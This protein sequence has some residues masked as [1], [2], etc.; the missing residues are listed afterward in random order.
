ML[1][2]VYCLTFYIAKIIYSDIR[3]RAFVCGCVCLLLVSAF[4][5]ETY[6]LFGRHAMQETACNAVSTTTTA[7]EDF[8]PRKQHF[9]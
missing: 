8:R 2:D 7:T 5:F 6:V 4:L 1:L 9:K 3:I